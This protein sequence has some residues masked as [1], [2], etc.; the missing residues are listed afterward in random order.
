MTRAKNLSVIDKSSFSLLLE[1]YKKFVFSFSW[2]IRI[3]TNDKTCQQ[4]I[5]FFCYFFL[6]F[7][8]KWW[9]FVTQSIRN[10]LEVFFGN[11]TRLI[12]VSHSSCSNKSWLYL[13]KILFNL[14]QLENSPFYFSRVV[15]NAVSSDS[16]AP[17]SSPV[18]SYAQF[19]LTQAQSFLSFM[20]DGKLSTTAF[21]WAWTSDFQSLNG[22]LKNFLIWIRENLSI[23]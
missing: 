5:I 12:P 7:K 18:M 1:N 15:E 8:R 19:L 11:Q 16:M 4:W 14:I 9:K 20:Y 10:E 3:M 23:N 17:F 2:F 22:W 6:I 21:S 13:L